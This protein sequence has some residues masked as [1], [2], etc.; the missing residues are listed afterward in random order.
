MESILEKLDEVKSPKLIL[1]I[2]DLMGVPITT[3][4]PNV[5]QEAESG[6]IS[7]AQEFQILIADPVTDTVA[8]QGISKQAVPIVLTEVPTSPVATQ[9]EN[10][11]I[12]SVVQTKISF[13]I[14]HLL[15]HQY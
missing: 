4:N 14:V 1:H 8:T 2:Q 9:G 6:T 7:E 5:V 11:P 12:P 13:I 10:E 15:L 3:P